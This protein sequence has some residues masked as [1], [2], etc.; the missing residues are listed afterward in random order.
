MSSL[1]TR[2][3]DGFLASYRNDGVLSAVTAS[4]ILVRPHKSG[5]QRK[6]AWTLLDMPAVT[7]RSVDFLVAAEAARILAVSNLQL[8]DA[9]IVATGVL[10]SAAWLVTNDAA[11]ARAVPSVVP[12][13]RVCLLSDFL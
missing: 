3:V 10:T 7:I 13:M 1:A 2:V 6:T 4:E 5:T 11:L 12:E 9:L 8:A